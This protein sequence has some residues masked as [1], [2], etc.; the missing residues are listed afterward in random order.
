MVDYYYETPSKYF[1]LAGLHEDAL[2]TELIFAVS[3]PAE[4]QGHRRD[5]SSI[6]DTARTD[7]A[8]S[9]RVVPSDG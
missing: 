7:R 4:C 9:S 6:D 5:A 2:D 3:A 1:T 8:A